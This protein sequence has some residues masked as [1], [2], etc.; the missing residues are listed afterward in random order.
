MRTIALVESPAQLLNVVEW[1][2]HEQGQD[3]PTRLSVLILA[4][5]GVTSRSTAVHPIPTAAR[6]MR[7]PSAA[8]AKY[9]ALL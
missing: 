9:S 8:L 6:R 1:A 4:P 3:G 2:H 5:R 7:S